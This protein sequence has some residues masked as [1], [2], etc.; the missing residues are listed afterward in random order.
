MLLIIIRTDLYYFYHLFICMRK[1]V[2][3]ILFFCFFNQ[4]GYSQTILKGKVISEAYQLDNIVVINLSSKSNTET[5]KDGYFSISAKPNDTLMFSGMQIIGIQLKL[6]PTDFSENL[7]FVK[8]RPKINQLDEVLIN[9]NEELDAV[10]MGILSKPAKKFS[11]AER[12]LHEATTGGGSVPLNPII[13]AITG[14]TKMLK[15]ELK[16]EKEEGLLARLEA[17]YQQEF[18]TE[19]LKIPLDYISGFQ[20]Y[21]VGDQN[22]K[23]ALKSKNKTMT[24]FLLGDLAEEYKKII[25]P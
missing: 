20:H 25:A 15:K 24:A 1:I 9:K 2:P 8:L 19:S 17:M 18:Y 6:K 5:I 22:I 13:N 12:R 7:F 14:R 21:V 4:S 3:L 23:R 11:P 10:K 16:V